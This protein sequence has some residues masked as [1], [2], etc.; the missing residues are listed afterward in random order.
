MDTI[1]ILHHHASGFGSSFESPDIPG[2]TGGTDAYDAAQ[3]EEAA[4]FAL[5]CAAEE[6]G[7]PVPTDL[8]FELYVPAGVAVAA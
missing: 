8:T 7:L 1:R 3:A 5:A 6:Q 4:G 2:L